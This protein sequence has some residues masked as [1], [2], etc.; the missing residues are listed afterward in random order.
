[1]TGLSIT[2]TNVIL[3]TIFVYWKKKKEF[4]KDFGKEAKGIIGGKTVFS[5]S[6]AED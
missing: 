5:S 2:V 4:Q 6:G 3:F 1:M